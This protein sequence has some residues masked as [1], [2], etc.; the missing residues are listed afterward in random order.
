MSIC[1]IR[2]FIL[3]D[4]ILVLVQR[5][6]EITCS[7]LQAHEGTVLG[8]SKVAEY[9]ILGNIFCGTRRHSVKK[10]MLQ[11]LYYSAPCLLTAKQMFLKHWRF[12]CIISSFVL[13][14]VS[15]AVSCRNLFL[16]Q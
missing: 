15:Q 12:F 14:E 10:P 5:V 2:H 11:N 3:S 7:C 13:T 4:T 8:L 16:L 1:K 6:K 9:V